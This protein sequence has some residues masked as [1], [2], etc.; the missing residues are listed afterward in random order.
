MAHTLG[1]T[2]IHDTE[3]L[4]KVSVQQIAYDQLFLASDE[5]GIALGQKKNDTKTQSRV[6]QKMY[7]S[8]QALLELPH[9]K[10]HKQA[11]Q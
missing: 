7:D 10:S 11:A 8:Y 9:K 4:Q 3:L 2:V 6:A 5:Y 1:I